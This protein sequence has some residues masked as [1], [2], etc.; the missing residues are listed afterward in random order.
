HLPRELQEGVGRMLVGLSM[1]LATVRND[2]DRL[3]TTAAALVDSEAL[4]QEMSKEVRTFSH[5]LHPPLL[6]EAGLESAL[7]WYVDGFVQRSKITVDLDLPK[8][9]G[10]LPR[11]MEIAAFRVVQECLT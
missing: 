1:S 4:V 11:E 7:R 10:R 3:P 6:D 2:I 8:E 9:L 5:L